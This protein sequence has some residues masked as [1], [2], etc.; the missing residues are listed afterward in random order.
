GRVIA[1]LA[2]CACVLLLAGSVGQAAPPSLVFRFRP[3]PPITIVLP[4]VTPVPGHEITAGGILFTSTRD[5]SAEVYEMGASG[6]QQT[7]LTT[8]FGAVADP[9]ESAFGQLAYAASVDG[10]WQIFTA[11]KEKPPTQATHDA[12]DDRQPRWLDDK[13]LVYV[14]DRSG[15]EDLWKLDTS[16]GATVDLTQHST[17]PDVDPAPSPNGKQI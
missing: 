2:G 14:S 10:H 3:G 17:G 8:L 7:R 5:G 6:E 16:T 1:A 13:T 15:S 11:P 9:T 4:P 12:G